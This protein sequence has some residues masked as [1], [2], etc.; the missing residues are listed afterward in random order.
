MTTSTFDGLHP[1]LSVYRTEKV[2]D[3]EG[4]PDPGDADPALSTGASCEA[5]LQ[6]AATA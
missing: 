5:P 3:V 6:L 1:A 4:V 2:I